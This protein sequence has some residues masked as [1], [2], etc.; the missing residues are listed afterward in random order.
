MSEALSLTACVSNA[1]M[2]RMIGAS[3]SLSIKSD[4]SGSC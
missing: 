2:S 3:S 1:L 4:G